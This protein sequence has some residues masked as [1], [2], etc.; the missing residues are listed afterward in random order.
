[1]L[2]FRTNWEGLLSPP[3]VQLPDFMVRLHYRREYLLQFIHDYL[4][5]PFLVVIQM[6]I[7]TCSHPRGA[8]GVRPCWCIYELGEE[9]MIFYSQF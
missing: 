9:R 1:M 5:L 4:Q 6:L 8:T 2:P 3:N 7:E